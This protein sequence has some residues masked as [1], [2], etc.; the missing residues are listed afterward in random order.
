M[1]DFSRA[2]RLSKE[3]LN[4]RNITETMCERHL[5]DKMRKLD[6]NELTLKTKGFL[7]RSEIDA[8]M[9]RRDKIV[10]IYDELIAK[11]GEKAVL[12]DDPI[13]NKS[14]K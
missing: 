9:A 12:Y 7:T 6:R 11:K 3:L 10:A 8:V 1:I 14:K 5:L 2:F 13:A 4:R